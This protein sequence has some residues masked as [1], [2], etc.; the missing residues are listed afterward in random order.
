MAAETPPT[1][2]GRYRYS[3]LQE[4]EQHFGEQ[5]VIDHTNHPPA[6]AS[7]EVLAN[8][9]WCIEQASEE[10]NVYAG[11]Q[12]EI[13]APMQNHPFIR[14]M[15]T[16]LSA[17]YLA[18]SRANSVPEILMKERDRILEILEK[19]STRAMTIPDLALRADMRPAMSN[20]RIDRRYRHNTVRKEHETST[21]APTVLE[22]DRLYE[23]GLYLR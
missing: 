15:A 5:F 18:M 17:Y 6:D 14:H 19:L 20:R 21:D 22:E 7:D 8:L 16:R 12:Y 4:I 11:Q 3:T 1:I 13:G 2:T 9:Y 10:I 23:H